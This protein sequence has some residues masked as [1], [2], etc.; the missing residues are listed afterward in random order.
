MK[1]RVYS[2]LWWEKIYS[3]ILGLQGCLDKSHAGLVVK[4]ELEVKLG[5]F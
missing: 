1:K 2:S 5:Y 4:V 3:I